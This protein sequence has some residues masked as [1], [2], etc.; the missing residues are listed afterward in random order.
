MN[1]ET[2]KKVDNYADFRK[3]LKLMK[4]H[5]SKAAAKVEIT[6][7]NSLNN[8]EKI[9]RYYFKVSDSTYTHWTRDREPSFET[10]RKRIELAFDK[11]GGRLVKTPREFVIVE[12]ENESEPSGANG[13]STFSAPAAAPNITPFK[14]DLHF[15]YHFQDHD[16]DHTFGRAY[17]R[18]GKE[19]DVTLTFYAAEVI[20][21]I[22]GK[23]ERSTSPPEWMKMYRGRID[24]E[25]GRCAIFWNQSNLANGAPNNSYRSMSY[26]DTNREEIELGK[27][28]ILYF[29]IIKRPAV[30]VGLVRPVSSATAILQKLRSPY[31]ADIGARI[32]DRVFSRS[33]F[34]QKAE[35]YTGFSKRISRLGMVYE[36]Y[37]YAEREKPGTISKQRFRIYDGHHIVYESSQPG[38]EVHGFITHYDHNCLQANLGYERRYH[39]YDV[40]IVLDTAL[41]GRKPEIP[42]GSL[43]GVFSLARNNQKAAAGRMIMIPVGYS[44]DDSR[45]EPELIYPHDDEKMA[46]LNERLG[47]VIPF[48]NGKYDKFI[49]KV[50]GKGKGRKKAR[51][52]PLADNVAYQ[53]GNRKA[54][55]EATT[56]SDTSV[57]G[58]PLWDNLLYPTPRGLLAK[59]K[60][61]D[62]TIRKIPTP[63]PGYADA[64][65]GQDE[66]HQSYRGSYLSF[67]LSS[68]QKQ[69]YQRLLQLNANDRSVYRYTNNQAT[70]KTYISTGESRVLGSNLEIALY[71]SSEYDSK[72]EDFISVQQV[73]RTTL[74]DMKNIITRLG[75]I[76]AGQSLGYDTNGDPTAY[77][78]LFQRRKLRSSDEEYIR[79][80]TDDNLPANREHRKVVKEMLEYPQRYVAKMVRGLWEGNAEGFS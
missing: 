22:P 1:K 56:R 32:R 34:T 6:K 44:Y 35:Y 30:G 24:F 17:L 72:L 59:I 28:D 37:C 55:P 38:H 53:K 74:V 14:K 29:F 15:V 80:W 3:I 76:F 45:L 43:L 7:D 71:D 69:V 73:S 52:G 66:D 48:L 47:C 19:H 18:I 78:E 63:L 13:L 36:A 40:H 4:E 8:W 39:Q 31:P 57:A 9:C 27:R 62:H 60:K 12:P 75:N 21:G 49:A 65:A 23:I 50:K 61:F 41:A 25:D 51:K 5:L 10:L 33:H 11:S 68:N 46:A 2:L 70:G 64:P 58:A 26:L 77:V 54:D 42:K 16:L 79:I 20:Q 67:R